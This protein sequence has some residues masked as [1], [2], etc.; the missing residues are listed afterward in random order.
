MAGSVVPAF[1]D[2][3]IQKLTAGDLDRLYRAM[4]AHGLKARTIRLCHSIVRKALADAARSDLVE[5]NVA[6]KASPPST[7]GCRA[8]T[9]RIWSPGELQRVPQ[10]RGRSRHR[11]RHP[12]RR[13]HRL[14]P[15]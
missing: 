2:V 4:A 9:F 11:H 6:L 8:P 14:P 13:V 15:G 3:R 10:V 12:V 5:Q 7:T 1:G